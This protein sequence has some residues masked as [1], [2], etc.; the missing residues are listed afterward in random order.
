MSMLTWMSVAIGL[1]AAPTNLI[2]NGDF[3]DG[4]TGWRAPARS[5]WISVAGQPFGRALRVA[6]SPRPGEPVWHVEA[7]RVVETALP[8]ERPFRLSFWARSPQSVRMA[9]MIQESGEPYT[10]FGRREV[11]LTP[12]W[13]EYTVSGEATRNLAPREA[14]AAFHF[15]YDPGTVE[16][17]DVRLVLMDRGGATPDAPVSLMPAQPFAPSAL[18]AW[19]PTGS[20]P[21]KPSA[22]PGAGPQ[23]ADAVVLDVVAP[24][25]GVPWASG[26]AHSNT[27]PINVGDIVEVRVWLR[28]PSPMPV[29]VV[30]EKA[31][32]PY[33]KMIGY[34]VRPGPEW[35]EYVFGGRAPETY[36]AGE[37]Q[38]TLHLGRQ[39]GRLEVAG[40]TLRN[41]GRARLEDI[42]M[43]IDFF[44]GLPNPDDW[45]A[46]AEARIEAIR[47]G[48]LT[49]RVVDSDGR[50][51]PGAEVH[52]EQQR[53]AFR[54]GTAAVAR[55]INGQDEDARRYREHLTRLFNT[56]V[57]ENDL[58]WPNDRP[59]THEG[60]GQALV[61][62]GRNNF[63]VRGH[64]LV[65][66]SRR[67]LPAGL[68]S[69]SDEELKERVRAH[70]RNYA[71]KYRGQLYVWDVVNEAVSERELWDRLGWDFF[72][73]VFRLT[74]E[75][76]PTVLLAY[77]DFNI[78]EEAAAG[79]GHRRRAI[80]IVR[81]AVAA[82][83]PIDV[84]GIQGHVGVPLTPISRVLEILDEVAE[85]GLRLEITEFDT[86]GVHDA[87]LHAQHT[88][89]FLTAC[90]SHPQVDAFLFW[91]FW[92]GAHWRRN[93]GAAMVTRDWQPTPTLLAY[94]DLVK[95]RWWTR[96]SGLS[97]AGGTFETRAF[98][99]LHKVTV[100]HGDRRAEATVLTAPGQASAITVRF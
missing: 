43:T 12:E 15:N 24:P 76:D 51:V 37:A 38:F 73:E 1:A 2:E 61:W 20:H 90:F 10:S 49:V 95:R 48:P 58:K 91:G 66:G 68:W 40:L 82:G 27:A 85:T 84:F 69:L 28:A 74:R 16:L 78:T 53:H 50:P 39:S 29:S 23:G 57:F 6:V 52:V 5:E 71:T 34:V 62:L 80:E 63:E 36:A 96:V 46:A 47:K 14:M 83:A 8:A 79:P 31:S 44:G 64:C 75:A 87:R 35:R 33:T 54:F 59:T 30:V 99:G 22:A 56:V 67:Y 25:D 60:I 9:A 3:S 45:R 72:A 11:A 7:G 88:V 86:G 42:P 92:E 32:E 65:W 89:D 13:R 70:V 77:N 97:D 100:A 19:R 21:P 98:Y 55:W 26:F 93:E 17:A 4:L 18:A 81:Q 41:L 94:E